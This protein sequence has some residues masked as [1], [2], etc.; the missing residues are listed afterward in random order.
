[1]HEKTQKHKQAKERETKHILREAKRK[2]QEAGIDYE[3]EI[4]FLEK[5]C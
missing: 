4:K 1:M 2:K 3:S 5:V